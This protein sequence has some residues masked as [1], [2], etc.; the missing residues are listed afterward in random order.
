ML[1]PAHATLAGSGAGRDP[2]ASRHRPRRGPAPAGARVE[3]TYGADVLGAAGRHAAPRT[4]PPAGRRPS[5]AWWSRTSRRLLRRGRARREGGGRGHARGPARQ[6]PG[7]PARPGRSARRPA[8]DAGRA[9][10]A[11]TRGAPGAHRLRVRRRRRRRGPGSPGPAGSTSRASTTPSWWRRSGATTCAIEGVVVEYLDGVDDLPAIVARVRP[12][13]GRRLGVLVDH[14]VAG[15]QGEP[16]RRAGRRRPHVLV[17]GH[18]FIDIWQAVKP[19][20]LGIAAWPDVPRGPAVEGGRA[21]RRSAGRTRH[22]RR[23]GVAA[24]PGARS[25]S[26]ADLEPE[27][28]GRV[29]ELIDFVTAQADEVRARQAAS[30]PGAACRAQLREVADDRV[31][32]GGG[33]AASDQPPGRV[34]GRS[35]SG[36]ASSRSASGRA[37]SARR[38][39]GRPSASRSR[40]MTLP[41]GASRRSAPR[42]PRRR[43]RPP[44]GARRRRPGA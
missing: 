36:S 37:A 40:S 30:G 1:R 28:L 21:A 9:R 19:P 25:R 8:G 35:M 18:P 16:D 43:A 42:G 31:R 26:Y 32:P 29:E 5:P 41:S 27:L 38:V 22:R 14:L 39:S 34:S 20:A 10:P 23:R 17:V 44:R 7:V 2:A 33:R 11:G 12:G 13:P 24:H 15:L 6:A 4:E 3:P